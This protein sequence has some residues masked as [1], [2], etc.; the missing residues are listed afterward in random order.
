MI[1]GHA[2]LEN[3]YKGMKVLREGRDWVFGNQGEG[4]AYG[5][6]VD[7]DKTLKGW[8]YVRWFKADGSEMQKDSYRIG[9]NDCYDLLLYEKLSLDGKFKKSL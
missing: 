6:I 2:T 7:F 4:S 3:S 8:C 9:Y 1:E 5:E